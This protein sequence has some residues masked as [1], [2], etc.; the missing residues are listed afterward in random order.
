MAKVV[1]KANPSRY[2]LSADETE[3]PESKWLH[4]PPGLDGL[5]KAL[6]KTLADVTDTPVADVAAAFKDAVD[7]G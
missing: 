4:N 1:N 7:G 2:S 3:H 5:V 6:L